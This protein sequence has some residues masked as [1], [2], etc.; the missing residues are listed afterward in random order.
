VTGIKK[1][2]VALTKE[3][4]T[5]TKNLEI[6]QTSVQ[7]SAQFLLVKKGLVCQLKEFELK[8][9]SKNWNEIYGEVQQ[10]ASLQFQS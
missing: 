8:R 6:L 3:S 10:N 1:A 4:D 2:E 9:L 5:I 7:Q